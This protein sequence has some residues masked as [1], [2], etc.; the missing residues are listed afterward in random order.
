MAEMDRNK[1]VAISSTDYA[2]NFIATTQ[3]ED[4]PSDAIDMAKKALIDF[5]GIAVLGSKAPAGKILCEYIK[6]VGAKEDATVIC[7]R[8]K[9]SAELAALVNAVMSH[10]DDYGDTLPI[11]AKYNLHPSGAIFSALLALSEKK[12]L[13]GSTFFCAYAVGMEVM[14]RIGQVIGSRTSQNGWHPVPILGT[15]GATSACANAMKLTSHQAKMAIG[16]S[17]SLAGGVAGNNKTMVKGLHLGNAAR[18][19]IVSAS[20]AELGFIGS[21]N[22]FEGKRG[23]C[24]VFSGQTEGLIDALKDLGSRWQLLETGLGFKPYPACRSM[25]AS[26]DSSLYLKENFNIDVNKISTITIKTSPFTRKLDHDRPRNAYEAKFSPEFCIAISLLFGKVALEHFAEEW[27]KDPR[28]EQLMSKTTMTHPDGWV[29]SLLEHK[30][31]IIIRMENGEEYAH[32]VEL[33]KGEPENPVTV[34]ELTNKFKDNCASTLGQETIIKIADLAKKLDEM[35]NLDELFQ[36][37]K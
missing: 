26:I 13:S 16:I 7:Q 10:A 20:I 19:G 34:E 3:I 31:E 28:I 37:L 5:I 1:S 17:G 2:A 12:R 6:D 11:S 32:L 33:P 23:F 30:T 35:D 14:Y 18:N 8:M 21:D 9:T 24:Q 25:H 4:V 22:V 29:E 15:I 27:N 36:L